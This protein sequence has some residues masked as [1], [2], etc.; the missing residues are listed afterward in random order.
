[1][2]VFAS[3]NVTSACPEIM[4]AINNANKRTSKQKSEESG[5]DEKAAASGEEQPPKDGKGK[6]PEE[7]A[8]SVLICYQMSTA[9]V[10]FWNCSSC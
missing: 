3:D 2:T 4:Q 8:N 10:A 7:A 9:F 6:K 5:K 1:M